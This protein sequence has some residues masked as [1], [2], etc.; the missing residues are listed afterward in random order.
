MDQGS[1]RLPGFLIIGAQKSGTTS[2]A[3]A[4]AA[5]PDVHVPAAKEAHYFGEVDDAALDAAAYAM[6]FA[7]GGDERIVGEAT[8]EYL[9]LPEA[10]SQIHRL[11]PEVRCI[12]IVRNPVDRA[13]SHY[14]H[15]RREAGLQASFEEALAEEEALRRSGTPTP[16][17]YVDRGRY[18]EQIERFLDAGFAR[19]QLLVLVFDDLIADP[20]GQVARAEVFIGAAPSGGSLTHANRSTRSVLPAT[21]RAGLERRAPR[22]RLVRRVVGASHRARVTEEMDP[23]TRARLVEEFREPNA[24][25]GRLLG[26]DLSGWDR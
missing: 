23:R 20:E 24:A 4:L 17:G 9:A 5:N 16:L 8:P 1:L 7:D 13:W 26:R 25:L 3:R 19:D 10:A 11:L 15:R 14:W 22:S 12:A 2:L 6:F 18:A 21:L